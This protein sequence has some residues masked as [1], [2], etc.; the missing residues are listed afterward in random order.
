MKVILWGCLTT[1]KSGCQV[2]DR[3]TVYFLRV[4]IISLAA[5]KKYLTF[6][7]VKVVGLK[8]PSVERM[9]IQHRPACAYNEKNS[10]VGIMC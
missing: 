1:C 5:L 9:I 4:R 6:A 2:S 8:N 7:F 10:V 3:F